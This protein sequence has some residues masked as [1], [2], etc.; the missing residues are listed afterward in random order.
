[1]EQQMGTNS[2]T[3][4]QDL[5]MLGI[6][7]GTRMTVCRDSNGRLF[8]H[9]PNALTEEIKTRMSSLGTVAVLFSPNIYHHL[10]VG[11]WQRAWPA[12]IHVAPRQ[13]ALKRPDLKIDHVLDE[14]SYP[15]GAFALDCPGYSGVKISP[16]RGTRRWHEWECFFDADEL[17]VLTDLVFNLQE[18]ENAALKEIWPRI[19]TLLS[20]Q[21]NRLCF[22]LIHHLL[23]KDHPAFRQSVSEILAWPYQR[24]VLAH[25]AL[26]T[27]EEL[28][29]LMPPRQLGASD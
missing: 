29:R 8:V 22:P 12:A 6:P 15:S 9:S 1:M 13:L 18:R 2:W 14:D 3:F 7:M 25:G 26:P 5:R 28:H 17:L 11:D 16:L 19:Y 27:A 10:Y 20:G 21:R 23:V 4:F 24:I